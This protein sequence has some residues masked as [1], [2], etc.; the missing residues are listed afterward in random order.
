MALTK[1][2]QIKRILGVLEAK[3]PYILEIDKAVMELS[4]GEIRI[5]L[6]VFKGFVTDVVIHKAQRKVFKAPTSS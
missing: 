1:E 5:D 2:E 6:R 4:S 3:K